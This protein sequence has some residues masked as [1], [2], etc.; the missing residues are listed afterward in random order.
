MEDIRVEE[1]RFRGKQNIN[2]SEV[3]KYLKQFQGQEVLVAEYQDRIK[4]NKD[5]VDEF[6]GSKYTRS[7][8]G[9]LAKTKANIASVIPRLIKNATNRRWNENKDEKHRD[10]ASQGWYRY[11]VFFS[12]PVRAE[13]EA[14]IRWN[15]YSATMIVKINGH[16]KFLYD[17]INIKKKRV[18]HGAQ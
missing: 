17:M 2:W 4:I 7:L 9:G 14:E 12:M 6:C 1:I 16:G 13:N 8:K 5:F 10:D 15:E 18:T 11:D 3:R